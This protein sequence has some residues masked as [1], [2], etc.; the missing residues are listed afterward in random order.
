LAEL[1]RDGCENSRKSDGMMS[2]C[3]FD[4]MHRQI[5]SPALL[6]ALDLAWWLSSLG[7][8]IVLILIGRYYTLIGGFKPRIAPFSLVGRDYSRSDQASGLEG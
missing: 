6:I 8:P 7:P 2:W 1:I 5:K 4:C 3:S